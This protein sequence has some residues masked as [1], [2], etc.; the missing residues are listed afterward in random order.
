MVKDRCICI[1]I[2]GGSFKNL[3]SVE[4]LEKVSLTTRPHPHPYHIQW[5][6]NSGKVKV[7]CTIHV[8]FTIAAYADCVECD[9]VPMQACAL[10]LGQPWKFDTKFVHYGNTNQYSLIHN[11]R[12]IVLLPMSPESILKDN[13]ARASR[14]HNE[15]KKLNENQIVAKNLR[16]L[17]VLPNLT[18]NILMKFV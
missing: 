16:L 10:L 12:P 15:D 5:F 14:A 11:D 13:L 18:Q 1:I 9:V 6:N 2:D 3:A 4:M 17:K 8:H 7:T